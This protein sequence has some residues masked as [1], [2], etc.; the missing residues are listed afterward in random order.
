MNTIQN[1]IFDLDGTLWDSIPAVVVGWNKALDKFNYSHWKI[2]TEEV[3]PYVGKSQVEIFA[4]LFPDLPAEQ[5]TAFRAKC[6]E[7][8]A[9]AIQTM[10]G[11]IYEGV[12]NTLAT[13]HQQNK[14]LFIVSN[15]EAGYIELFL[16]Q[17]P[18]PEWIKDHECWGNTG[19]PKSDNIESV[20]ER[21]QLNKSESIYIGDTEGD[22]K[23][24]QRA[25]LDFV[26]AS[27]GFGAVD[28]KIP[29]INAIKD[30]L[31]LS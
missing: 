19:K 18:H 3:Y 16:D 15:C 25:G 20:I 26:F 23:A 2:T 11:E 14:Q 12:E 28:A 31:V 13:L 30:L 10:G 5:L 29:T 21:N 6:D 1:Y 22:H 9:T 24:S 17:F 8:Q 4:Q 27:Y 7:Y